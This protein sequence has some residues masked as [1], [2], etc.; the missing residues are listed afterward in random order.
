M[1]GI[2][3]RQRERT[4]AP[5]SRA[6][7]GTCDCHAHIFGPSNQYPF[8]EGHS[9]T[10]PEASREEYLA[11]LATIGAERMVIVQPSVY[12]FDNRCT[13][14]AVQAFGLHRARSIVMIPPDLPEAE[15]QTLHD[16]G[17]R[18][19]RFITV[20]PGGGSLDQLRDVAARIAPFGWHIQMYVPAATWRELEPTMRA[21]PVPVVMDHMAGILADQRQDDADRAAVMRLLDTGQCWVKL[22]GYRSSVEGHP[23]ADVAPLAR[24][25]L[26]AVPNRCVWGTDWPHPNMTRHMPDDGALLDLLADWVPDQ[27]Q[28][29]RI[30]VDNP[31]SLYGFD[32]EGR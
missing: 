21:L 15:L 20:S 5:Q 6:P 23:Y 24:S 25:L 4:S 29:H 8:A 3:L 9:Y 19:V 31:A 32:S 1:D 11:M 2:Y 27:A 22:S 18:G 26:E 10:P 7:A 17:A 16:G 28:R 30:L 14:E 12:G 13:A